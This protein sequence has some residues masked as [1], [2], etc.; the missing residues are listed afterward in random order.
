MT[1]DGNEPAHPYYCSFEHYYEFF[2]QTGRTEAEARWLAEGEYNEA[3]YQAAVKAWDDYQAHKLLSWK[4]PRGGETMREETRDLK[5]GPGT[6]AVPQVVF[7][8]LEAQPYL[9]TV[10]IENSVV[11]CWLAYGERYPRPIDP[12]LREQED[13]KRVEGIQE[14]LLTHF[15]DI[16][17][18]ADYHWKV[19]WTPDNG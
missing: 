14:F 13:Q 9:L 10:S 7:S 6:P 2:L 15:P 17:D 16:R 11:G 4:S 8:G 5:W 3:R 1:A 18:N 19:T 12:I